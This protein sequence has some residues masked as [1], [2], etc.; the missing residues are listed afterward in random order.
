MKMY[1]L[2]FE[3]RD[4]ARVVTVIVRIVYVIPRWNVCLFSEYLPYFCAARTIC[5][6]HLYGA[7]ACSVKISNR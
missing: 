6:I 3:T 2:Y 4:H 5:I 7:L 1:I